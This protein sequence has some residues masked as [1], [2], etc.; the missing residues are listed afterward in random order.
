MVVAGDRRRAGSYLAYLRARRRPPGA[1]RRPVGACELPN[2]DTSSRRHPATCASER[3]G[4]LGAGGAGGA[5]ALEARD[6]PVRPA[7]EALD[8]ARVAAAL[9]DGVLR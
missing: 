8:L 5:R 3:L 7:R 9:G 2:Q 1:A 6:Q 4:A